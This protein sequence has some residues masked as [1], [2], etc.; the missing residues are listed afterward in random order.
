MSGFERTKPK[1]LDLK[2]GG[3]RWVIGGGYSLA[4]LVSKSVIY[5]I[6]R[7]ILETVI[8]YPL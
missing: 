8:A 6:S 1:W 5:G 4:W 7:T 2:E 3:G